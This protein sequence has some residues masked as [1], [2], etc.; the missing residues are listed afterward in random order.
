[1]PIYNGIEFL[2][3]SIS[4]IKA[5]TF[6]DWELLIGVNGHP[7]NS[8]IFKIANSYSSDKIHIRE[9]PEFKGKSITLNKLLLFSKY[10]SICLLDVDD[11]WL[12]EKLERQIAYAARYDVIGTHCQYFGESDDT[13]RLYT[14]DISESNFSDINTIINSSSMINRRGR[15]ISWDFSWDG[16]EDYDLWIR[17][18]KDGWTFFNIDMVLVRHRIHSDSFFNTKN[19]ALSETLRKIRFSI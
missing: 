10:D 12:P 11:V 8:E 4:S 17:L 18:I 3:E 2:E 16:V 15:D 19:S 6:I 5:Q 7:G 1:M 13:P 14:G 9:F